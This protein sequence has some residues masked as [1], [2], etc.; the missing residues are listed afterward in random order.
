[1]VLLAALAYPQSPGKTPDETRAAAS[2]AATR[3]AQRQGRVALNP[4]AGQSP[5]Q[6]I[7]QA[8]AFERYKQLA[9]ER[10]ARKQG[11]VSDAD[12]SMET[13]RSME[14]ARPVKATKKR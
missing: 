2:G 1:M 7:E 12:R 6:T 4:Q 13:P 10:E 9:A 11:S 5:T 14:T 3:E 8:I